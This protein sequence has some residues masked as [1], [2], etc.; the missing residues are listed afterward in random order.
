M[1]TMT[2][3]SSLKFQLNKLHDEVDQLSYD[4]HHLNDTL[5]TLNQHFS[6][7]I[8]DKDA[9]IEHLLNLL[10]DTVTERERISE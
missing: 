6:N 1:K 3:I 5:M 4:Y 7:E 2:L 10:K 8:A 9:D